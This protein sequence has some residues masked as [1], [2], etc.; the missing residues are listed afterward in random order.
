MVIS[1]INL[2]PFFHL[3]KI[4]QWKFLNMIIF[5]L[6]N[7][8]LW[9]KFYKLNLN[10]NKLKRL[11]CSDT[12]Y[13]I[14]HSPC[15]KYMLNYDSVD[16]FN[17]FWFFKSLFHHIMHCMFKNVEVVVPKDAVL[18]QRVDF[19]QIILTMLDKRSRYYTLETFGANGILCRR[20]IYVL[21]LINLIF[22]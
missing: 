17:L 16:I 10:K 14:K 13:K 21:S 15:V 9:G 2:G 3:Q 20:A 12:T 8:I 1:M 7:F 5:Q 22:C 18:V 4:F 19:Q 6:Q 11:Q